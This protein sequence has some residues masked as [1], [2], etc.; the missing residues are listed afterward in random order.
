MVTR[1]DV[2]PDSP[3]WG[4]GE[5]WDSA[6]QRVHYT[7][8]GS[9]PTVVC[10]HGWPGF[11]IDYRCLRPL[12][13][14]DADV[15]AID[16][17]GFGGSMDAEMHADHF[18]RAGQ[19][20]VVRDVFDALGIAQ[21]V[22]VGYDVGSSVA[23]QFARESP[24]RVTGLV[25]GNPMHP[26]SAPL[27]LEPDH[28]GEFWYQ[29]FHQ[30]R[31][32]GELVDG[33]PDAV[34]SY[35]RHFYGHWGHRP[36]AFHPDHLDDLVRAYAR[37]GAFSR[38]VNWY[39]SGSSTVF[40]ALAARDAESPPPVTVPASVLWGAADPLYP[41]VFAEGLEKTLP[42]HTLRVL[43]DVGHFVPLEAPDETAAA[44]RRFL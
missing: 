44:V 16:L 21:A 7:R 25:L 33:R 29:D 4:H 36:A 15:V 1:S 34:L 10:L 24:E 37:R 9:G 18:G 35:L 32:A 38:S 22:L 8:G 14:P 42:D 20:G 11:W 12:L 39:R 19:V 28:R 40:A 6:G 3:L 30:L 27:A 17:R 41:P 13:E 2:P 31:L 26:A 5:L 43:D 23:I